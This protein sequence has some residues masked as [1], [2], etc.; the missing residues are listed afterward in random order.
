MDSERN[1]PHAPKY[2]DDNLDW[3]VS[4]TEAT[5]K[6][7]PPEDTSDPADDIKQ[8][9][10]QVGR[11]KLFGASRRGKSHAHSGAYR[12]DD[13]EMGGISPKA[14]G[15]WAIAVSD[16]A[17]SC[18]LSRVGAH[19]CVRTVISLLRQD[20]NALSDPKNALK[21]AVNG[22]LTTLEEEAV[23]RECDAGELSCTLL[24]LLWKQDSEEAGGTALSF[25]AG[26]GLI[27]SFDEN[28]QLNP[29]ATQDAGAFA[30][31]T[32]FLTSKIVHS[33]RDDRFKSFR[34]ETPPHG[35]LVMSD[36]IADDLIPYEKNGPILVRE[37]HRV[38]GRE[39]SGEAMVELLGYEK[40]GSFD[41]RTLAC[42]FLPKT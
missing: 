9:A 19:L 13:F 42:A 14:P 17:G 29:L 21:K 1:P 33:T 40:R 34:F 39:N 6:N 23:K 16:G 41:D 18:R 30:G 15:C 22:A 32:H 37:L 11:W 25:Q 2:D 35:F 20:D 36:G 3:A 28:S 7:I 5:W 10:E 8:C 27:A 12:E 24:V 26:D 38:L 31:E 4:S